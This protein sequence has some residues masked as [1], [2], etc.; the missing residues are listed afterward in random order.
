MSD[1][2]SETNETDNSSDQILTF[3]AKRNNRQISIVLIIG[4]VTF[5]ILLFLFFVRV[6]F[7]DTVIG[8]IRMFFLIISGTSFMLMFMM[9]MRIGRRVILDSDAIIIKGYGWSKRL[10]YESITKIYHEC[11]FI[12]VKPPYPDGLLVLFGLNGKV[13]GSISMKT[14]NYDFLETE[15]LRRIQNVTK[16]P[17]YNREKELIEKRR[18]KRRRQRSIAICLGIVFLGHCFLLSINLI[19][20]KENKTNL[21]SIEATIKRHQFFE[22][23]QF[24]FLEYVFTVDGKEYVAKSFFDEHQWANQKKKKNVTILYLPDDP[25]IHGLKREF[26][27]DNT[28]QG[29]A[30]SGLTLLIFFFIFFFYGG[31]YE[32]VTYNGITYLLKPS[33]ILEDR[34]D[35]SA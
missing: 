28:L 26:L 23:T 5:F 17:V 1:F 29:V 33:Q 34:L 2:I 12:P 30:A 20:W 14:E 35:E 32:L 13:L 4:F 10:K 9:L 7:S 22:N 19:K 24:H 31:I 25:N 21:V 8:M 3:D 6:P 18:N 15:L 27:Q 11:A 16:N